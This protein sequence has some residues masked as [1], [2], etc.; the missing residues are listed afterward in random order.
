MSESEHRQGIKYKKGKWYYVFENGTELDVWSEK[1]RQ[2][3]DDINHQ[4]RDKEKG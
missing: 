1:G 2:Y 4:R 3:H